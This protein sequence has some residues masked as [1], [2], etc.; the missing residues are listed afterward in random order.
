[1]LVGQ[2]IEGHGGDREHLY[3][4]KG[5]VLR[6]GEEREP[7]AGL[8]VGLALVADGDGLAAGLDIGDEAAEEGEFRVGW[9][10]NRHLLSE[11][12]GV[13]RGRISQRLA[14]SR[15]AIEGAQHFLPGRARGGR[16]R[17]CSA[18]QSGRK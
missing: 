15:C 1:M 2:L 9:G 13:G 6:I 18:M 8:P 10:V 4:T 5:L 17:P 12:Q 11:G 7:L 14:H 16:R 3:G